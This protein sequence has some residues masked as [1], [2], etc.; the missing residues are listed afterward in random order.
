[1]KNAL[2]ALLL[3]AAP[4]VAQDFRPS[5]LVSRDSAGTTI[6]MCASSGTNL[7][8]GWDYDNDGG[9]DQRGPCRRTVG[10]AQAVRV[11]VWEAVGG[12]R[13][14][15]EETVWPAAV[16]TFRPVVTSHGGATFGYGTFT[17]DACESEGDGLSYSFDFAGTVA[18]GPCSATFDVSASGVYLVTVTVSS[19]AEQH[20]ET[21]TVSVP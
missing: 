21:I 17:F 12:E 19:G 9:D 2:A 8:F 15:Y 5:V 18:A 16:T 6:D 11:S 13:G 10:A 14:R 20:V 3:L 7:R 1:M 4:A